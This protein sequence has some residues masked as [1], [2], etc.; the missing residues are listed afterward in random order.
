MTCGA[1]RNRYLV[2]LRVISIIPL[3]MI[4]V[5]LTGCMS[6]QQAAR[7]GNVQHIKT[8]LALGTDVNS[9]TFAGDQASALHRASAAGQV[10]TVKFLIEN[11]ANV[12]IKN[13][14]SQ[15]PIHYA[16]EN[17]HAEI[18]KILLG[19]GAYANPK[20]GYTKRSALNVAAR[21]GHIKVAEVLY[22]HGANVNVNMSEYQHASWSSKETPLHNAITGGHIEMVKF[23]I[24]KGAEVNS[25]GLG[26]CPPLHRTLPDRDPE[27][28]KV[29]II[30]RRILQTH[31]ADP[32]ISC[33][34]HKSTKDINS[35]SGRTQRGFVVEL[36][37]G[38]E[39]Q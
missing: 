39:T 2:L 9:R 20:L 1:R 27:K 5:V 35:H 29:N 33:N 13:E 17:G 18:V 21:R 23:L 26:G 24:S 38:G 3:T 8:L 22:A 14:A 16:A 19:N 15:L 34:R 6:I 32:T 31:G 37:T 11:G 30:I 36:L 28:N 4:A 10:E 25:R 12:N 7:E